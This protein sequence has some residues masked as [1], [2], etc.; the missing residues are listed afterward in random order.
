MHCLI[1]APLL[2]ILAAPLFADLREAPEGAA[3]PPVMPHPGLPR[4][5]APATR[6]QWQVARRELQAAWREIIGPFP[7]RVPLRLE[8]LSTEELPDHT[9]LL[10]RYRVE[11]ELT[12]EAYL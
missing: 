10:L 8:T 4:G 5:N 7:R 2:I 1:A 6:R 11:P 9:R 12:A 3:S